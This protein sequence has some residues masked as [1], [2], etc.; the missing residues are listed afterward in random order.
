MSPEYRSRTTGFDEHRV[1]V[2]RAVVNEERGDGERAERQRRPVA[3]MT[4]CGQVGARPVHVP[5]QTAFML[6]LIGR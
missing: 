5:L 3:Q 2:E 6:T 4:S 1:G